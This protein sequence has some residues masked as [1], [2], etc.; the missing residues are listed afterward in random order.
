MKFMNPYAEIEMHANR[1]PHWQQ[2]DAF[3]FVTWRL[4]DSIPK[5][6]LSE[7][8]ELR[9][10]WLTH[11]PKPW[12]EE[13][14]QEFHK[15]FSGKLDE[16]LDEGCGACVLKEVENAS[17]IANALRHFDGQRYELDS[18]VV[19]PNHVH[20]LFRPLADHAL[21]AI[22]K[23]WKGFASR[24]INKRMNR[25]GTLWQKDYWDRL[26]R[27]E[28]HL[29]KCREYIRKN[30]QKALLRDGEFVLFEKLVAGKLSR[31]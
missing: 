25:D 28:S 10:A 29:F 18:F 14:E 5:E 7:W 22:I 9:D 16:W 27:G 12:S 20:V 30:P 1:L 17:I 23:S 26:V 6:K 31:S 24:E 2:N 3:L 19:M 21:E 13:L 8:T 4:A 11:H 15:R